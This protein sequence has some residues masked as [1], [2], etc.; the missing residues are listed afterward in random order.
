MK[1][2]RMNMS[3]QSFIHNLHFDTDKV[4]P[5]D[6]KV[7]WN[8]APLTYK[9]YRGM[10]AIELSPEIPLTF[11][12][13]EVP[14]E[15]CLDAIGHLL[16]YVYGLNQLCQS[17]L[18]Q[19]M[20]GL[21]DK[22]FVTGMRRFVPS[23]G[24]L[25]P[26]EL[27]VYLKVKDLPT[28]VYHYDAAHHRLVSLR[29]G[30]YDTYLA[31]ALGS[32]CDL[33]SCFAV[34]FVSTLFWKNFFKYNNFAYRLQGLDAGVLI[35]QLLEVTKRQGFEAAVCFQFLDRAVNHLLGLTE[36]EESVYAM[37]PLSVEPVSDW[38]T[39]GIE[40]Q[41]PVTATELCRELAPSKHDFF[42]RSR[43]I[44]DYPVL[45]Q[46]NEA[47]FL[48]NVQSF[49]HITEEKEG[50]FK[51]QAV[52][53]PRL[54]R[55]AYDLAFVC[56]LR[57]SPE[58][59]FLF[60]K[61]TAI[62]LAA[63]L[64]ETTTAFHYRNDLSTAYEDN[65]ARVSLS[66]CLYGV[67]GIP[68]GAYRYDSKEHLLVCLRPGDHRMLLNKGMA[69]GNINFSQIPLCLHVSGA[70]DHLIAALGFRGYRIQQM[71]AGMLVQRLLLT[72]TALGMGGHPL[73]DYDAKF[74]DELYK[75]GPQGKTNL[76]QIPIGFYRPRPRL[77]GRLYG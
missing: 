56:R 25:Y 22:R 41:E 68:D 27:Y 19:E 53:L 38:F 4:N 57:Y 48:E 28:G 11:A 37:V 77:Q 16:W 2:K 75:L 71:E 1:M 13:R 76:I 5:P 33:S 34:V 29:E 64:Q 32:P 55:M 46:M 63:L 50:P 26:N 73:L 42:I 8:D 35:G 10:P 45:I 39:S 60:G 70:Q 43:F 6:W 7:N 40:P 49:R 24:G 61:L 67:E 69:V 36:K 23:G 44:S 59:D 30:D 62:K 3:L 20:G 17:V 15:P 12:G 54:N 66:A 58:A 21:Q 9:L 74:C 52:V 31:K 51:G 72:A 14:A 18:S 47:S 65:A